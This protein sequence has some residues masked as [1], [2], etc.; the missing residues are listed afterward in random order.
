[1]C[2]WMLQLRTGEGRPQMHLAEQSEMLL[3]CVVTTQWAALG[4]GDTDVLGLCIQ[5]P[6]SAPG[7]R[8]LCARELLVPRG[9]AVFIAGK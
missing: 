1:M 7:R 4:L 2:L 5:A 9:E 8:A 3:H 6:R